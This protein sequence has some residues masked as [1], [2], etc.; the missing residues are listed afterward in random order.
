MDAEEY[1]HEVKRDTTT[2]GLLD[3]VN[4]ARLIVPGGLTD[5]EDLS[6][7]E[8]QVLEAIVHEHI[9]RQIPVGSKALTDDLAVSSATIR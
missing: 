9:A 4:A 6:A 8:R 2:T 5:V 1:A 7:R 3:D